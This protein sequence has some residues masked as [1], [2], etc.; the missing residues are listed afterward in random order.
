[1][2]LL[3]AFV[4]IVGI[5]SAIRITSPEP[6]K[7]NQ[8]ERICDKLAPVNV[9]C[10][11]QVGRVCDAIEGQEGCTDSLKHSGDNTPK[12]TGTHV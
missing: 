7:P 1:M 9:N 6:E 11:A 5:T 3:S 2:K 4:L 10:T 8:Y 12:T